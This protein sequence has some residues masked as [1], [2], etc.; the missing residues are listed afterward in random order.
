MRVPGTTFEYGRPQFYAT[1]LLL[2]F[3]MQAL[4]MALIQPRTDH[5]SY[6]I[7]EG[8][9]RF[10]PL[11]SWSSTTYFTGKGDQ[12]FTKL[13]AAWPIG[14]RNHIGLSD[15]V[16]LPR[17]P[18]LLLG[19][20]LGATVWWVARRLYGN[21]GGYVALTLYSFSPLAV[22][23]GSAANSGVGAA[24][25][26]FAVVFLAI[27]LAH[28]LYAPSRHWV[29]R[30]L[31]LTGGLAG[32]AS[33]DRGVLLAM[34]VALFFMLY[35]APARRKMALVLW[36]SVMAS[37]LGLTYAT[38][39]M[40]AFLY[41]LRMATP[42]VASVAAVPRLFSAFEEGLLLAMLGVSVG[43]FVAWRRSCYFG[44]WAPLLTVV[45]LLVV[46]VGLQHVA[47]GPALLVFGHV[48]I[49][50]ICA[51]LLETRY[52]HPVLI[53]IVALLTAHALNGLYTVFRMA[54]HL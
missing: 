9:N 6:L 11:T 22:S 24:L 49:A 31:L 26:W 30:F 35:L 40:I 39:L 33:L 21:G 10:S 32:G 50:G 14:L 34:P 44:N 13:L 54:T 3:A 2:A 52:R 25:G 28:N 36:L 4:T 53:G 38:G 46:S 27:G 45:I 8:L 15:S 12:G 19:T 47:V 16:W 51:D 1:L 29:A 5:E 41:R 18:F 23:L 37:S 20:F 7:E 43:V 42:T 17:I 48:F